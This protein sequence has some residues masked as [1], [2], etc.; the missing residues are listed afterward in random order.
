MRRAFF[1]FSNAL[2]AA[3]AGDLQADE[4]ALERYAGTLEIRFRVLRMQALLG[5]LGLLLRALHVNVFGA[6]GGLGEDDHFVRQH[7]RESPRHGEMLFPT[8][9]LFI[10][11]LSDGKL[12]DERCVSRQN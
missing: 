9:R 12:A 11:D 1:S 3:F 7:F 10:R 5:A 4:R 8:A 6:L 2:L